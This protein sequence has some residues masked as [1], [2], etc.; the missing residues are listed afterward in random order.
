M[1]Y[2]TPTRSERNAPKPLTAAAPEPRLDAVAG[3]AQEMASTIGSGMLITG[4]IVSTGSVQIFGRVIGD[5]HAARLVICDGAQVDGKVLA[6]E[7]IIEGAFKGTIHANNVKL[8]ATAKVDGEVYNKSLAIEQNAQFE[9]VARR[10]EK[11]IDAPSAAQTKP[12]PAVAP[13]AAAPA[14]A[15]APASSYAPA[16]VAEVVQLSNGQAYSANSNDRP[17]RS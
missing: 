1:S 17:W 8:Q 11:A 13:G 14:Y 5:I 10:L 16:P 2:F 7:A 9:G 3:M 6:Q 15:P 4:N 12:A